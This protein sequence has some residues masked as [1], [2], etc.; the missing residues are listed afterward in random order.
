MQVRLKWMVFSL[1]FLILLM[2]R[3]VAPQII[4]K[5]LNSYL[6]EFSESYVARIEDFDL[7]L[8]RGAY[9]FEG[10]TVRLKNN[11][12]E[13]PFALAKVIDVSV[14]WREIFRG[15]ILTDVVVNEAS[16][17]LDGLSTQPAHD[18]PQQALNEASDAGNKL[19][20][21]ETERVEFRNSRLEYNTMKVFVDQIEGRLS[22]VT[23]TPEDPISLLILRGSFMGKAAVKIIGELNWVDKPTKWLFRSEVQRFD[24]RD[25]NFFYSQYVPLTFKKGILDVYSEVKYEN[26]KIAGYIKPFIQNAE[27]V[28]DAG[29]FKGFLHFGAEVTVA[30]LNL[31][32]R[33]GHDNTVATKV[34][35]DYENEKFRWNLNETLAALFK[36]GYQ[37]K[38]PRGIENQLNLKK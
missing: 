38:L 26:E 31:F 36:N 5:E 12:D 1:V 25:G 16:I 13:Q 24:L 34:L 7:S 11:L 10:L 20:P 30:F 14:A 9:R 21:V 2:A 33:N 17:S 19:F 8:W 28:G 18:K 22:H 32:F 29:D 3:A 4:L 15:R 23:A 6:A 35:F 27:I 37:E